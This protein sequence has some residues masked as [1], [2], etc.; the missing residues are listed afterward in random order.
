MSFP[1]SK[2]YNRDIKALVKAGEAQVIEVGQEMK[3]DKDTI[4]I[5]RIINTQDKTY[6]RYNLVR[7]ESGW[8]FSE[9]A[10]K[11]FDD[12]G[13]EY[14]SMS[15][16][17][18]GKLWG[19]DGL[20]QIDRISKDSKYIIIKIDWYDRQNELKISFEEEDEVYED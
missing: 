6:I 7:L 1:E 5:K 13:N 20:I 14:I 15:G 10:L 18:S 3:I 4:N 19:Q 11:I 17:W 2:Y 9:S 12:K 8:S 16:G